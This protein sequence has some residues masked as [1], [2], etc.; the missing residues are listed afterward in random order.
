[1]RFNGVGD[2][3]DSTTDQLSFSRPEGASSIS[4][5]RSPTAALVQASPIG[6]SCREVTTVVAPPAGCRRG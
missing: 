3:I 6:T 2:R 1:V 5:L 4:R